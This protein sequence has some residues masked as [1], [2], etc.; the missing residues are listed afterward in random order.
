MRAHAAARAPQQHDADVVPRELAVSTIPQKKR[1]ART[2]LIGT[3]MERIAEEGT[4]NDEAPV[5][6]RC[7]YVHDCGAQRW[8]VMRSAKTAALP[9]AADNGAEE[10]SQ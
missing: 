4:A 8:T 3:R 2:V 10:A 7:V 1:L 6:A 9:S 5:T